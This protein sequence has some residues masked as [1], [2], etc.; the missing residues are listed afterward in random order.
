MGGGRGEELGLPSGMV[1]WVCEKGLAVHGARR[2]GGHLREADTS[3]CSSTHGTW[4]SGR[5]IA[6]DPKGRCVF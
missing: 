3:Q 5:V 6:K 1:R 2:A 4:S